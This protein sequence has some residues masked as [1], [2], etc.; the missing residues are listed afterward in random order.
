MQ[1]LGSVPGY[2]RCA[3]QANAEI[4][5]WGL[6]EEVPGP[7]S[8]RCTRTGF[9]GSGRLGL[10]QLLRKVILAVSLHR[11]SDPSLIYAWLSY[12]AKGPLRL[13]TMRVKF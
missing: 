8:G 13:R 7:I 11:S 4:R 5:Y 1:C 2:R 10:G 3:R 9:A 12:S 6:G